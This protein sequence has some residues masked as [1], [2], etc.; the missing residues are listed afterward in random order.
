M[1]NSDRTPLTAKDGVIYPG[2]YVNVSIDFWAQDNSYGKRINAQLR[3]VQFVKD[4]ERL[5]GSVAA[6]DDFAPIP[7]EAAQQAVA[8]GA[9]AAG[10]GA[11]GAGV[12]A[13]GVGMGRSTYPPRPSGPPSGSQTSF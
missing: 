5:G 8:S 7:Q 4:G 10:G 2:C 13:V 6:A 1:I 9:A 3:G 11:T 12:G